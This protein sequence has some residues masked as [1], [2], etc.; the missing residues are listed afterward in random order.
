MRAFSHRLA[1][2]LE[3][4]RCAAPGHSSTTAG[5]REP[6]KPLPSDC[7]GAISGG[8]QVAGA[9]FRRQHPAGPFILDFYCPQFRLAVELDGSQ[10]YEAARAAHDR[11]GTAYL[12]EL[13]IRVVRFTDVEMLT[14]A[15]AV[16]EAMLTSLTTAGDALT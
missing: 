16:V 7:S 1:S 3:K 4:A 6:S 13:G 8:R 5:A 15:E 10:H 11:R 2:V 12:E 14:R 9:K